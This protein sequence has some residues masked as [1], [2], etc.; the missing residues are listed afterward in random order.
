MKTCSK[1]LFTLH[2]PTIF[3]RLVFKIRDVL[4]CD[5]LAWW[6]HGEKSECNVTMTQFD[7]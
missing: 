7:S 6:F 5:I 3:D 2:K 4:D 1:N